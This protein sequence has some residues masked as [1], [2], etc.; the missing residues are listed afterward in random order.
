MM[1]NYLAGRRLNMV[2][3]FNG[4]GTTL[5]IV[6]EQWWW[7]L[8]ALVGGLVLSVALEKLNGQYA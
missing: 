5:L 2:D 6:N 1:L 7:A 4:S 3:M 8:A